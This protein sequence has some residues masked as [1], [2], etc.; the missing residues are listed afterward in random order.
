MRGDWFVGYC[1]QYLVPRFVVPCTCVG[2]HSRKGF[3]NIVETLAEF[4][5]DVNAKVKLYP[6]TA[7]RRTVLAVHV[8]WLVVV[9]V[10]P[11][12]HI[13]IGRRTNKIIF[14]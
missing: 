11:P 4:G 2:L 5:A 3:I 6:V 10:C 12:V 7:Q 14:V 8:M 9:D 13:R 1:D